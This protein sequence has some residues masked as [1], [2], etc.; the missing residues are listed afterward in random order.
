MGNFSDR[1]DSKQQGFEDAAVASEA[2][3]FWL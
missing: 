2:K 3:T 1:T